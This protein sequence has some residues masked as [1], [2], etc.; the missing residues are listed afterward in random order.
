MDEVGKGSRNYYLTLENQLYGKQTLRQGVRYSTRRR[1]VARPAVVLGVK[2]SRSAHY[3]AELEYIT[4]KI[5]LASSGS[6]LYESVHIDNISM[7]WL[8]SVVSSLVN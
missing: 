4:C 1:G 8:M 5:T 3:R 7:L 2:G 6:L